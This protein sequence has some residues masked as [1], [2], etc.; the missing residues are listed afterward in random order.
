MDAIASDY[1][2]TSYDLPCRLAT[3]AFN[4]VDND[5]LAVSGLLDEVLKLAI[6]D[7]Q[8]VAT[9]SVSICLELS[10]LSHLVATR[11]VG[12]ADLTNAAETTQSI[13]HC[14]GSKRMVSISTY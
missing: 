13:L 9:A 12:S 4:K 3:I 8:A 6:H 2:W 7:S 14:Q 5:I 11:T 1:W 10:G